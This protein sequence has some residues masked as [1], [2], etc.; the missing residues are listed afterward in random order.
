MKK[1]HG[2]NFV[3]NLTKWEECFR[4]ILLHCSTGFHNC[5]FRFQDAAKQKWVIG[6]IELSR[7]FRP[8]D[9][10]SRL[11]M[12]KRLSRKDRLRWVLNKT[13]LELVVI[14]DLTQLFLHT[15]DS[16]ICS[17]VLKQI[18]SRV[19]CCCRD[20]PNFGMLCFFWL[21]RWKIAFCMTTDVI[22]QWIV[23]AKAQ[24]Y[25]KKEMHVQEKWRG[26]DKEREW[27]ESQS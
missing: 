12:H 20:E 16:A 13:W 26:S 10:C 17:Q 11:N 1:I 14:W 19:I 6:T 24:I 25:T 27:K 3:N 23:S 8:M 18:Y 22:Q 7:F 2:F 9:T 15:C 21:I 4:Y 5:H